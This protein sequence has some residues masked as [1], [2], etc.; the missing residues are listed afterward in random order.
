MGT[1]F[2]SAGHGAGDPGAVAGGTKEAAE[3]K[4]TCDAVEKELKSRGLKVSV[5]PELRVRPTIDWINRQAKRGDVAL[6]LHADAFSNISVRG[7]SSFYIR[8]NDERRQNAKLLLEAMVSQVPGLSTHGQGV[9]PD[10]QAAVRRLGFCCDVKVPSLL[11]ELGFITNADDRALIQNKR[12][13]YATGIANGLDAWI[14]KN[15]KIIPPPSFSTINVDVNGQV[16]EG[17]GVIVNN[18]AYIPLDW[19][20]SLG[21]ING[22]EIDITE[23]SPNIN[24]V[25][26]GD[27][28]YIKAVDLQVFNIS[29]G[30]ED[31]T[32]TVILT[33]KDPG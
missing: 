14:N 19:W 7:A 32:R 22:V 8:N 12:D 24:R 28:T 23:L 11:I 16:Y 6:E 1:I 3:M 9:K 27:I 29:I 17:K 30:W 18:N 31:A 20:D 26:Q 13:L 4:L 33:L 5:V 15:E 25:S 21:S 2:L 10:T